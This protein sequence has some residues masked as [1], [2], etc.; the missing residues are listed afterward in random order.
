MAIYCRAERRKFPD[1]EF[2]VRAPWGL[3]HVQVE[4]PHTVGGTTLTDDANIDVPGVDTVSELA[5]ADPEP[6]GW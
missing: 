6:E 4:K 3:C 5:A 1:L 2:E